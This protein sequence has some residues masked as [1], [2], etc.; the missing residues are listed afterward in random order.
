MLI[1]GANIKLIDCLM[2]YHLFY[3]QEIDLWNL[4]SQRQGLLPVKALIM[5]GKEG[6]SFKSI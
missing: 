6:P 5:V 4:I 1:K 2:N 3:R